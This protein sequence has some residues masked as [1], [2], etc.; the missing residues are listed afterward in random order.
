MQFQVYDFTNRR[1]LK[2]TPFAFEWVF[3]KTQASLFY[4]HKEAQSFIDDFKPFSAND[5]RILTVKRKPKE[6]F[7]LERT[8]V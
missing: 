1:Y 3:F 5:Y 4:T 2:K 7:A 8:I 6:T